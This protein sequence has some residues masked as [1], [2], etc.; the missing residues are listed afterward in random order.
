MAWQ[1]R[2]SASGFHQAKGLR[3]SFLSLS[4]GGHQNQ[5]G[6]QNPGERDMEIVVLVL[7]ACVCLNIWVTARIASDALSTPNQRIAQSLFVWPLPILGALLVLHIQHKELARSP[8]KYD[9]LPEP[10][11]D[12]GVSGREVRELK[13]A[14][15]AN[16]P[17]GSEGGASD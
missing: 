10:G 3:I 11:D 1:R 16:T 9:E 5:V 6:R 13:T 2:S 12:F 17:S 8:G 7:L 14:L 15:E 4:R